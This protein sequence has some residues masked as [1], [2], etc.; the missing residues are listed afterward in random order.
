MP[1]EGAGMA[2]A[3]AHRLGPQ[4]QSRFLGLRAVLQDAALPLPQVPSP[5]PCGA[6]RSWPTRL[7]NPAMQS[8]SLIANSFYG[9][10]AHLCHHMQKERKKIPCKKKK[11]FLPVPSPRLPKKQ[12]PRFFWLGA[13]ME[14]GSTVGASFTVGLAKSGGAGQG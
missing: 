14:L 9:S 4:A 12:S 8:G 1:R 7:T 11:V 10:W 6:P 5:R 2:V 13:G 3:T